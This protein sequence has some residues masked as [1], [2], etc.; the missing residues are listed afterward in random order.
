MRKAIVREKN[1]GY[2]LGSTVAISIKHDG[3]NPDVYL[4]CDE[5]NNSITIV[6]VNGMTA[7]H[8]DETGYQ[9]TASLGTAIAAVNDLNT[10]PTFAEAVF[11]A[12][13][14]E[15]V[16]PHLTGAPFYVA[17]DR[18]AAEGMAPG[19]YVACSLLGRETDDSCKYQCSYRFVMTADKSA[20]A[21]FVASAT[22]ENLRALPI[23]ARNRI[24][25]VVFGDGKVPLREVNL[26]CTTEN[27]DGEPQKVSLSSEEKEKRWNA[28]RPCQCGA[29]CGPMDPHSHSE[30]CG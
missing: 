12:F 8:L 10:F 15:F 21:E 14:A 7:I 29:Q 11:A 4:I 30:N 5:F 1:M 17:E 24:R 26:L 16:C 18:A 2:A 22:T 6:F 25:R 9:V 28:V 23:E 13:G 19:W 20:L 3:N 27:E